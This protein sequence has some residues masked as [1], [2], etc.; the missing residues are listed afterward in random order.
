MG[1]H[2]DGGVA[3]QAVVDVF[4]AAAGGEA[5]ELADLEPLITE[6]NLRVRAASRGP[7]DERMGSTVV[8]VAVVANGGAR[9]AVVFNVGD[10]RC[11]RLAGDDFRQLSTDH[12][13]V[14]ELVDA[15]QL[16]PEDAATHHLR[17]VVTRALGPWETVTADFFVLPDESCRLLLCSDGLSDIVSSATIEA[18]LRSDP[19]PQRAALALVEEALRGPASDNIT[20]MVVDVLHDADN[21]DVTLDAGTVRERAAEITGPRSAASERDGQ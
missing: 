13:H 9:S 5:L 8:G 6:C 20:A 1:G 3:S 4:G 12:S 14:Q 11:Y 21:D 17:H 7:D 10:S 19:D 15:G 2:R 16:A 18:L